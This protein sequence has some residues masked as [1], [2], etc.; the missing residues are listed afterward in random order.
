MKKP[1]FRTWGWIYRPVSWEGI[2]VIL[3]TFVF[4]I[5]VFVAAF[6]F[7]Q[8]YVLWYLSVYC[9]CINDFELDRLKDLREQ[10]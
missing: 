10:K 6:T 3:V 1:W 4:C 7:R 2:V 9:S 5:N 8:R